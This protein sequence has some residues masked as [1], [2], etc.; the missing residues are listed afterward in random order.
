M[1]DQIETPT[2][3]VLRS[4]RVGKIAPLGPQAVPSG[5]VK[6]SVA[7]PVRV[8]TLNLE[9]DAQA[10]LS[11]HG[12]PDKAV[13]A[14]AAGQY[15][16]WAQDFPHHADRLVPGAFGENLTIDGLDE[17]DICVGDIHAIGTARLQV[18][19]PRQPC[20]KLGLMFEDDRMPFLMTRNGRS[21]WYY[22][23]LQEGTLRAGDTVVLADRPNADFP[24]TQLIR[25]IYSRKGTDED[26]G[27]IATAEGVADWLH[28]T[29]RRR[30]GLD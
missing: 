29:A 20:F 15:T 28:D 26:F 9:G 22:R 18:C 13:Y 14:Y 8:S 10:D 25:V 4:V 12:G 3:P 11:V 19:Q 24:L 17:A 16:A 6:R 2:A 27:K 23:V 7:G 1:T 30:L 21:G 5:F